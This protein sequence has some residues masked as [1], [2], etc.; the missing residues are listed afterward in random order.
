MIKVSVLYPNQPGSTFDMDYYLGNHIPLLQRLLA[1]A[2]TEVTVDQGIG[3]MMPGSPAPFLAVGHLMFE[4]LA[5]FQ[6]AFAPHAAAIMADIPK[7]TNT[8]PTV[9]ISEVKL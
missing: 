2:M 4:S 1:G 8:Q 6:Q 3:G 9:Q 5:G 7:Y